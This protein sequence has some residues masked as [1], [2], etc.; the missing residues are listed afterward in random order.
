MTLIYFKDLYLYTLLKRY[1]MKK[2]KTLLFSICLTFLFSSY[3]T[4]PNFNGKP[5]INFSSLE[6]NKVIFKTKLIG[7]EQE[8]GSLKIATQDK[9][10]LLITFKVKQGWTLLKSNLFIG[11]HNDIPLDEKGCPN[12]KEVEHQKN[13]KNGVIEFSYT[14]PISK[15]KKTDCMSIVSKAS[16]SKGNKTIDAWSEGERFT[17]D[18]E[19]TYSQ[20]CLSSLKKSAFKKASKKQSSTN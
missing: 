12:L 16:V 15:I 9:T 14:I 8:V 1:I 17:C 18:K 7:D 6:K 20:F 2:V 5:T 11:N 13:H 10:N 19:I 3:I 4:Y